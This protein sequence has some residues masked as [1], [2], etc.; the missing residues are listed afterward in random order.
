MSFPTVCSLC[1]FRSIVSGLSLSMPKY[2]IAQDFAK[3]AAV[4]SGVSRIEAIG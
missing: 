1:W 3:I 2:A 4:V